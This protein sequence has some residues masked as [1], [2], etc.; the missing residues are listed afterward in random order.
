MSILKTRITDAVKAAMRAG[1]K[2]RLGTLRMISAAI[3]Q[4]EVD[5]RRELD[6]ADVLVILDKMVKQRRESVE[7]YESAGRD[8]LAAAEHAEIA[9]IGE[10]LPQPLTDAEIDALVTAAIRDSGAE[11]I[12][13]MGKAMGL[14]KPQVQG[15]ADMSDVSARVKAHLQ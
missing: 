15:R 4:K 3:K 9:I 1:D 14:L 5:E 12:R 10:F 7:Q 2:P 6:N 8:E 13:D 11:G